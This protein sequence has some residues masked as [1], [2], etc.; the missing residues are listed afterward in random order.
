MD[1]DLL[2]DSL[3]VHAFITWTLGCSLFCNF[4]Y[5]A[6][7]VSSFLT[8]CFSSMTGTHVSLHGILRVECL[9]GLVTMWAGVFSAV[10]AFLHV[11]L[12]VLIRRNDLSGR[13]QCS[14][15]PFLVFC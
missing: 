2:V 3:F 4:A 11:F 10:L 13:H 8:P 1:V 12:R 14:F 7:E 5:Y 15:A 6:V 9:A